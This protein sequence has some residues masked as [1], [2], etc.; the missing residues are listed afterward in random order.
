MSV[1]L[2]R[3]PRASASAS[4]APATEDTRD[5]EAYLEGFRRASSAS[6]PRALAALY[7]TSAEVVD[8]GLGELTSGTELADMLTDGPMR[9]RMVRGAQNGR[10]AV[11]EWL[12]GGEHPAGPIGV[13]GASVLTFGPK[14]E[15]T[16][17]IRYSDS[18]TESAQ[19]I[20]G[21]RACL[22]KRA[23]IAITDGAAKVDR[24]S[25]AEAE[26]ALRAFL[27]GASTE[28]VPVSNQMLAADSTSEAGFASELAKALEKRST[29]VSRC[30][31]APTW[32]ACEV[33]RRG[34]F[35]APLLGIKPTRRSGSLH[36]LVVASV[37]DGR[38]E[39]VVEYAGGGEFARSYLDLNEHGF[40]EPSQLVG[41][42]E[43][44]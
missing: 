40:L 36:A 26:R 6:D 39:S 41:P 15:V 42:S 17:E 16:T 35:T 3:A 10:I 44:N 11:V 24:G 31:S 30:V 21:F 23:P 1:E 19:V 5:L 43:C 37:R 34:D 20:A 9:Q 12:Y 27:G 33:E 28:R 25:S 29:S 8:H 2:D 7:A 14:G 18:S 22:P 32:A 13:R 4:T 38:V